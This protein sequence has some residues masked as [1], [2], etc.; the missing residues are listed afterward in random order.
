M[1]ALQNLNHKVENNRNWRPCK[2]EDGVKGIQPI[3]STNQKQSSKPKGQLKHSCQ[4]IILRWKKL[5]RRRMLMPRTETHKQTKPYSASKAC[6]WKMIPSREILEHMK[7]KCNNSNNNSKSST[8]TDRN[9][10]NMDMF[11]LRRCT[12]QR[13][14]QPI[15][16]RDRTGHS[17]IPITNPTQT[18]MTRLKQTDKEQA[19]LI[20]RRGSRNATDMSQTKYKSKEAETWTIAEQ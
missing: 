16:L 6:N 4:N 19:R 10:P 18:W 3:S 11:K 9:H 17:E 1:R 2:M 15:K 7:I 14:S 20:D 13:A 12:N 5:H 8:L